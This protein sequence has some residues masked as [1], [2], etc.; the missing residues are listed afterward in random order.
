MKIIIYGAGATGHK[1]I[2]EIRKQLET[3]EVIAITDTYL[4]P[5]FLE[6]SDKD[7]FIKPS[8]IQEYVFDYIVITPEKFYDEIKAQLLEWGIDKEKIVTLKDY[9]VMIDRF[10]CV[11]CG[12]HPVIWEDIGMN[13]GLFQR[14]RVTGAGRRKGGCPFC[15]SYD[16]ERFL[17]TV[18]K[19]RTKL[20]DC[21]PYAVL[22]FAPEHELSKKIRCANQEQYISVDI[23]PGR[24]DLV[25]D[26]TD[27]P[28]QN[29]Q[30]DYMICNHVME[31]IED[32]KKA[33]TEMRRCLKE[34]GV[35]ILTIPICWEKD[36]FEDKTIVNREER[37]RFFGQADHVRLYGKDV[38]GRVEQSG[39]E[40]APVYAR[41]CLDD[42]ERI[43]QG[44]AQE[45]TVFLCKRK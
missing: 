18:I 12:N 9:G 37:I 8:D 13:Y 22:H 19:R 32:E 4:D 41:D 43:R 1:F 38:V 7:F 10:Y 36:T 27:L 40:V 42:Y 23:M 6:K 3:V 24:A 11:L 33:F 34:D 14:I 26:I 28:F 30:F 21:F 20:L 29:E 2:R 35:L 25:A 17:Y 16:R 31:H 39:F 44:I 5:I 15:G 45:E